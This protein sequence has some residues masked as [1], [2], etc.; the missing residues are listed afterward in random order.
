M[1]LKELEIL[2]RALKREKAA[3]K[4][5]EEILE[6]K[7][8]D[9][10]VTS[11]KLER[12]L[13]EKSS[14]LQGVFENIIDAY[15]VIDLKGNVVKFNEAASKLFGYNMD[16]DSVNVTRLIYQED[17]KYALASFLELQ[18]KGY[19][20]NY[21][22]R[23][24]TKSKEIKW[25]HINASI[26][27]DKDKN[28]IAA[29]GIVRDITEIKSLELQKEKLLEKL[30][31]SNEEL[32]EY[33]QVVSHDLK[34]PLRSIYAL[35]EWIKEDNEGQFSEV[36]AANFSLINMTL[37]KMEQLITDVLDYSS[38]TS[39]N[40]LKNEIDLN[41]VITDI[42]QIL[43]VPENIEVELKSNFPTMHGNRTRLQQLFQNL[44][45]NAIRYTD[46]EK[47]LV[48]VDYLDLGDYLEFSVKDNGIG[49]DPKHHEKIFKIFQSLHQNKE[50]TGVGLSIVKKIV[51]SYQGKIWLESTPDIG[52]TFYFTLKK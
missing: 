4:A 28:P 6:E 49:I 47:G 13:D 51:E 52:T 25:V 38:V 14:Q 7:S 34:S 12:L 27:F 48:E 43:Y 23:V 36:T 16:R 33:A 41:E 17:Y 10:Y 46:K 20:K 39:E 18:T 35:V 2:Q 9:L 32:N 21:E 24:S 19:Y 22:A 30:G 37:E 8:R 29:Q 5:A 26:I 45:T 3:R 15:V 11:Q 40:R 1:S 44:L 42:C 50:S 31:K